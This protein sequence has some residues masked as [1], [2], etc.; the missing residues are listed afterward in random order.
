MVK[1]YDD[2]EGDVQQSHEILIVLLIFTFVILIG[3]TVTS[4]IVYRILLYRAERKRS[5]KA[6]KDEKI[7]VIGL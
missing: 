6:E 7:H 3:A 1:F 5:K 4:F 2:D